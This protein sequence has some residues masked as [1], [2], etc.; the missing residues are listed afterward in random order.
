MV[1]ICPLV[2]SPRASLAAVAGLVSR[3]ARALMLTSAGVHACREALVAVV[4]GRRARS[5]ECAFTGS[6]AEIRIHRGDRLDRLHRLDS[7]EAEHS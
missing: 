3:V 1:H 7:G 2:P 6:L 4:P 5:G